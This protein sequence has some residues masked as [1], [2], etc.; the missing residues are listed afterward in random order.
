MPPILTKPICHCEKLAPQSGASN[1]AISHHASSTLY[2]VMASDRGLC[3]G[4]NTALFREVMK[5]VQDGA[6]NGVRHS[7]KK[8]P[9]TIFV[10]VVKKAEQFVRRMKWSL[11]A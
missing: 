10:A 3:G 8:V 1:E 5:D 11:A 7:P 2:V 6:K 9:D 4:F